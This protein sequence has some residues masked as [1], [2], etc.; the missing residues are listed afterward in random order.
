MPLFSRSKGGFDYGEEETKNDGGES[1]LQHFVSLE[2]N[3]LSKDDANE[4]AYKKLKQLFAPFVLR[5]RKVDALKQ[6][7]PPKTHKLELVPFDEATRTVYDSILA[8]HIQ[9]KEN[10]AAAQQHLFTA[11]RKAANHP[12][13]LRSRHTT[14]EA[15]EHLAKHLYQYGY[16]GRHETC[17]ISHVRQELEKFSDFGIHCAATELIEENKLR[18]EELGR[19]LLQE[20]DLFSSPKFERLRVLLPELIE[21]GHRILIFSQWTL[22]MDLLGCLMESLDLAFLRLDGSTNI[23]ERQKMIDEFNNNSSIPVFLLSTRAGGMGINLTAADTCI[24]HDLDFNP[25]ND[26]QAEDRC[27]R[28]GQK[29]PVTVYKMVTE[30]TVDADIHEMQQKKSRMNAAILDANDKTKQKKEEEAAKMTIVQTAVNRF[31]QLTSPKAKNKTNDDDDEM[32]I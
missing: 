1:M 4:A 26:I 23:S 32:D 8:T 24:I 29:K 31:H 21:K 19:Y 12:L 28:I 13:L 17:K 15:K 5:R 27:H 22:C 11:L 16:F 30:N 9:T 3:D 7:L 6:L 14:E 10:G 2:S 20:Q 25:F 18:R